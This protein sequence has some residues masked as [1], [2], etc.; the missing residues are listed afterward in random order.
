MDKLYIKTEREYCYEHIFYFPIIN[1]LQ[2]QREKYGKIL[3]RIH[4]LKQR[5]VLEL[6]NNEE[7][8]NLCAKLKI[9]GSS[10]DT[11]ADIKSDLDIAIFLKEDTKANRSRVTE[12]IGEKTNWNY[13]AV[14]LND[15]GTETGLYKVIMKKGVD[16]LE[17]RS[18]I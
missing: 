5:I 6:M 12:I 3:E 9:F 18:K 7:I 10:I 2:G 4:P 14:F 11:R 17:V 15:M 8:K 16:L 13:D 1:A